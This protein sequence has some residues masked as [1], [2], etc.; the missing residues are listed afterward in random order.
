MFLLVSLLFPQYVLF[1]SYRQ[2]SSDVILCRFVHFFC[3]LTDYM[4]YVFYSVCFVADV[5]LG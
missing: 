4:S 3:V 5:K 1:E 2:S